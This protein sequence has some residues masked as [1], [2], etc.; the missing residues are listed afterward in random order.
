[1]NKLKMNLKSREGITLISLVVTIIILIIL[2]SISISMILGNNGLLNKTQTASDETK[3]SQATET[4]NLKITN[5][6]ISSYTETQ[7]LPNLQYLADKLCED[8]DMEYVLTASKEHASLDKIDVTNISSIFTK[9]KE[10]PYEFEINSSLQLASID[11]Q[12]ITPSKNKISNF[13][14]LLDGEEI[15]YLPTKANGIKFEDG[16]ATNGASINFNSANWTFN[17]SNMTSLDTIFTLSFS[18]KNDRLKKLY[19]LANIN[20]S[21]CNK[22]SDILNNE[23]NINTILSNSSSRQ[24]L[25][26]RDNE[27]LNVVLYNNIARNTLLKSSYLE[28]F[29]N[30]SDI[31]PQMTSS[32][33]NNY[34]V[35]TSDANFGSSW[36][37]WKAFDNDL[38]SSYTWYPT[39]SPARVTVSYP[40]AI[41]VYGFY[42]YDTGYAANTYNCKLQSSNDGVNWYDRTTLRDISK[43]EFISVDSI[44]T[45]IYWRLYTTT[46]Q[47]YYNLQFYGIFDE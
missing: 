21:N 3:K 11:G 29:K 36:D 43:G 15:D 13:K 9:L 28:D 40:K 17:I 47:S 7:Q 8:N 6:Q 20:Y 14:I 41:T 32:S 2:A 10:Y 38:T 35:T 19:E 24:Y 45:A 30:I 39:I 22:L 16:T 23:T 44:D 18:S 5:I 34:T 26:N 31:V 4:M 27:L 25:F 12:K 37:A 1:M 42:I 33:M 46:Q